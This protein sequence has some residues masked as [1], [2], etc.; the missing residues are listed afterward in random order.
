MARRLSV[1]GREA[2]GAAVALGV[3]GAATLAAA[4]PAPMTKAQEKAVN[5]VP[6]GSVEGNAPAKGS[7]AAPAQLHGSFLQVPVS[8]LIPGEVSVKPK[9]NVPKL[10]AAAAARGMKAFNAFNCVGCHMGNGGGGMGPALSNKFFIYGSSPENIYLTIVQGRP[11]GMPAWGAVLPDGIV[12]DLVAYIKSLSAAPPSPT[13]GT[14]VSV[15]A[16][17]PDEQVPAELQK[18]AQPWEH[19]EKFANGQKPE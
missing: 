19:T 11:N 18:S 7:E 8:N 6:A 14:T 15:S 9:L 4:Q 2:L 5:E 13:W 1:L 12:W 16:P 17:A 3:A 10:D